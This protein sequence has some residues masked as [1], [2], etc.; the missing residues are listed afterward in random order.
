MDEMGLPRDIGKG[1]MD[2]LVAAE[3]KIT[4][5]KYTSARQIL[6]AFINQVN[7]QRGKTLTGT[8]SR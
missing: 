6:Q 2:K 5:K 1:L 4:Q 7:S 3:L 8:R